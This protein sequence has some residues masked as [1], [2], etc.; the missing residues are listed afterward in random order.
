MIWSVDGD[1]VAAG[2]SLRV[3]HPTYHKYHLTPNITPATTRIIMK[4][5]AEAARYQTP[6]EFV[7]PTM[8]SIPGTPSGVDTN[9]GKR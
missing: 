8:N 4:V 3:L 9:S 5:L 1:V 2:E 7:G 6:E